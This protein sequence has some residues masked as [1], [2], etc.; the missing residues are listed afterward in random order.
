MRCTHELLFAC[1]TGP[2]GT[3]AKPGGCAPT[4]CWRWL[5]MRRALTAQLPCCPFCGC[6][7]LPTSPSTTMAFFIR[8]GLLR[9]RVIVRGRQLTCVDRSL[10]L[11]TRWPCSCITAVLDAQSSCVMWG[12]WQ[13]GQERCSLVGV[14]QG[15][16]LLLLLV[17]ERPALQPGALSSLRDAALPPLQALAPSLAV[18]AAGVKGWHVKGFR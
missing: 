15:G 11:T 17:N 1:A 10:R 9:S 8:I 7:C 13:G 14:R 3:P 16:A 12:W 6:R 18:E 5:R 4:G 2:P